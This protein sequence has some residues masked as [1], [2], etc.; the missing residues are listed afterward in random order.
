[1]KIGTKFADI[2]LQKGNR[3]TDMSI[4]TKEPE[5]Q[6]VYEEKSK[7]VYRL[8]GIILLVINVVIIVLMYH[9]PALLN[10]WTGYIIPIVLFLF[11]LIAFYLF[12]FSLKT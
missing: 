3:M 8:V 5:V 1:M 2:F 7:G 4:N 10:G 9:Y 12:I 6:N 11:L